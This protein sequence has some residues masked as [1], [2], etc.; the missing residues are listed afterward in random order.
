MSMV[1][2]KRCRDWE[3]TER[4]GKAFGKYNLNRNEVSVIR[5]SGLITL[6][7]LMVKRLF[8]VLLEWPP[9]GKK[10]NDESK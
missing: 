1:Y 9:E 3:W 10:H 8:N 2:E 5:G 6:Q 4:E 7:L